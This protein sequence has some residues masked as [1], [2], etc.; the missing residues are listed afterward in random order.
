[1]ASVGA[2]AGLEWANVTEVFESRRFFLFYF[3]A[4][5]A[6][7]LPKRVVPTGELTALREHIA[8]WVSGRARLQG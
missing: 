8:R 7:I 1:M 5:W 2:E 4:S 3:S 6:N